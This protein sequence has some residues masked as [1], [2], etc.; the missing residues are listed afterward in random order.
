MSFFLGAMLAVGRRIACAKSVV[1]QLFDAYLIA[2]NN[3]HIAFSPAGLVPMH[4]RFP[5]LISVRFFS[6]RS[7]PTTMYWFAF[8]FAC[9]FLLSSDVSDHS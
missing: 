9:M 7:I 8:F 5:T 3:M 4:A 6:A 1:C 2:R